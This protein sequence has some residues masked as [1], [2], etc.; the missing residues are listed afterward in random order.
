MPD[1][2]ITFGFFAVITAA[3]LRVIMMMRASDAGGMTTAAQ[4][5]RQLVRAYGRSFPASRL[6]L[7]GLLL[8][9]CGGASLLGGLWIRLRG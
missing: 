7:V 4:H 8:G 9:I 5:G 3:V 6:P 2:M 1:W